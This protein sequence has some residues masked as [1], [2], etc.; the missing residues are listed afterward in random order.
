MSSGDLRE[1]TD[2]RWLRRGSESGTKP[3]GSVPRDQDRGLKE[4]PMMSSVR[5]CWEDRD[6][7]L[8]SMVDFT[9]IN[10][11]MVTLDMG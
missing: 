7:Y 8:H 5:P 6:S 11:G 9:D 3:I 10:R 1:M 2:T 4:V